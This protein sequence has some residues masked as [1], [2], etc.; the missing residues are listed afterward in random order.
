[1]I[2]ILGTTAPGGVKAVIQ[3]YIDFG[4]YSKSGYRFISTHGG[5]NKAYDLFLFI[6]AFFVFMYF[7]VCRKP[8]AVHV[9]MTYN[10]SFWRKY[11]F[12]KISKR[13]DV[14]FICHLHGSEFKVYVNNSTLFRFGRIK[15]VVCSSERFVVLS[16]GWKEYVDKT[17]DSNC[18]V[19]PNFIDIPNDVLIRNDKEKK[20]LFVGALIPRKGV[21]DLIEAFGKLQCDYSLE[22]CGDGPLRQ[23]AE[24]LTHNLG[25]ESSV[26]FHG[27]L[28]GGA[29]YNLYDKCQ[30]FVLPSYNEG[31]PLVILEAMAAG[32]V[33]VSTNV[34]AIEEV[35]ECGKTGFIFNPGDLEHLISHLN[36]IFRNQNVLTEITANS[37]EL[38][39]RNYS[40]KA[41]LPIIRSIYSSLS[42]DV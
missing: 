28:E 30:I 31:L 6:K 9:H 1:M 18:V 15:D 14:P 26:N 17:F 13:F 39:S 27:W 21:L 19:V 33:V 29:K 4:V 34:G 40:S 5:R 42:I 36:Y 38:Y 35:V 22:I 37:R 12:F 20:I 25:L 7:I 32:C 23:E 24:R 10:G 11:I 8:H 41:V 3:S 16:Q 2:L